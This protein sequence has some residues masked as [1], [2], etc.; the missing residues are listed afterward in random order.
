[1]E[2]P[3]PPGNITVHVVDGTFELFR[4]FFGSPARQHGGR[5]VGATRSLMRSLLSWA[6]KSGV[7]HCAVAFD[8]VIESF[9]NRL[10]DGYKT[11]EGIDP[12][13]LSQFPLAEQAAAALGFVVWPM[14]EF[15]CDDALAT[16]AHRFAADPRVSQVVIVSPDK[17]LAQCVQGRRVVCLDRM[18]D[19]L[20]DEDGVRAK[21][22][23]DP[24]SIPDWLALVGD[25]AD[26]FP[27]IEG[28]GQK[29]AAAVLARWKSLDAI[30]ELPGRWNTDV[31]GAL[32]LAK[33]LNDHRADALLY[34]TLATLRTDVP[35]TESLDQVQ[36][37]GVNVEAIRA[38]CEVLGDSAEAFLGS[39]S[40]PATG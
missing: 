25:S 31:R 28:W 37:N 23:V 39:P 15:E 14:I 19:K 26:G 21:F 36:W 18:R 5:E 24:A 10:F 38:L 8:T 11:G 7:T 13:L 17:D 9:R 33:S 12:A 6:R 40:V 2:T 22:G 16:A 4:S 1:M 32:R 27:G 34:R 20:L 35:L 30:P 29:S 3:A